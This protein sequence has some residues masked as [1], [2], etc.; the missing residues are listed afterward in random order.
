MKNSKADVMTVLKAKSAF[1]SGGMRASGQNVP[2]AAAIGSGTQIR[3]NL[4]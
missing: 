1:K 3:S 4:N 2:S